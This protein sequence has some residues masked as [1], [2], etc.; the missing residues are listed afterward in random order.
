MLIRL[1]GGRVIDPVQGLDAVGDLYVRDGRIVAAPEPGEAVDETHDCRG[2]IVMAGAIDV[3]SH[4]AGGN[5]TLARLLLPELHVNEAP[6]PDGM[7]FAHARWS[8]W[9][10]GRL[11]AEMG[12]TTV[13]EPAL[14]PTHALQTHLELA[15]LPVIDKG[16]LTVVGN[17]DLLLK[18]L[19]ERESRDAVRDAVA[20][21]LAAS[22]GLGLKVINAGG[23][24]AFKSNLRAFSFDDEV[25]HYGLTSRR[26]V[27]GLLDAAAEIGVPHPLHV[28]CNNLGVPGATE[29]VRATMAGA[30]GRP[31]HLA[32]IQFYAYE[33]D[34]AGLFRSGAEAIATALAAHPNVSVDVG[35][36]MFGPTVT[37]SLDIMKQYSGHPHASPKKWALVD[38]DAEG[39]GIVPI[40]YRAKSWVNQL[41]WAIGLELFLLSP[42]PW[43]CLMTTDHP[44][45]GP[46]TSYP[47]LLHLLMDRGERERW[48]ARMPE[49][50]KRRCGLAALEREYTLEEVAI[51]TRAAPA[52]LLG[53]ADRGH[54]KPGAVA[55]IAVYDDLADRAAMFR[56][57]RLVLKDGRVAVRDGRCTGWIFGRTHALKPGYDAAM[58]REVETYL[59]DRYGVGAKAFA[60]PDEAFGERH[61][62]K[63]EP[64]TN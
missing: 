42:D 47:E 22:R 24:P 39:G 53:L 58:T 57:A 5:V 4:I 17:D 23:A 1:A 38:G 9:E 48:I 3:H 32:H 2:R 31:I 56:A 14:A 60:V 12:F 18:L 28:H 10:I 35:Q 27:T 61:V 20:H 8:S 7:P 30:E 6:S 40:D 45:G 55:D 15:D 37:I 50:A 62:F 34:P 13:I 46:F 44:N 16:A 25:P 21:A 41:Q 29:T 51:M 63:V 64:C 52:R 33:E 54:L 11:Y 36:V 49:E 26:I 59:T 43:R 19:R